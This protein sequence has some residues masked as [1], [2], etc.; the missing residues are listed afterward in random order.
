MSSAR[1]ITRDSG[2]D[3]EHF[4][5]RDAELDVLRECARTVRAGTPC[6]VRIDGPPGIGKTALVRRFLAGLDGFRVLRAAADPSESVIGYGVIHQLHRRLDRELVDRFPLLAS[7]GT[8]GAAPFAVGAD[9]LG[10]LGALQA[11]GPVAVVVDDLQW[12]DEPSVQALGFALRRLWGDQ[13]LI[14]LVNRPGQDGEQAASLR[15][16]DG[17]GAQHR[18]HL[19]G[20]SEPE[21]RA[22]A[23]QLVHTPLPAHAVDR[24]YTQTLGHPLYARALAVELGPQ[25]LRE[26]ARQWPVPPSLQATVQTNLARLP[27]PARRLVEALAVL[28]K[29]CSLARVATLAGVVEPAQALRDALAADLAEWWPAEPSSPVALRHPLLRDAVYE[30]LDP[31]RRRE[32]HA[33]AAPLVDHESS[34]LHRVA[35]AESSDPELAAELEAAAGE[36]ADRGRAE[37]AATYLLWAAELSGSRAEYERRLLTASLQSLATWRASWA[38]RLLPEVERCADS[39]LRSCVIGVTTLFGKGD[40]G[41]AESWLTRA[42]AEAQRRPEL[43]W[44]TARAA[45]FQSGLHL[46]QGKGAETVRAARLALS[47]GLLEPATRDVVQMTLTVGRSREVGLRTALDE[48]AHLP[49]PA[50]RTAATDLESLACRGA[51]R[52]MLGELTGA[53]DDLSTVVHRQRGGAAAQ[54]MQASYSY[55]ATVRYLLGD[56]DD[57]AITAERG[58]SVVESGEQLYH[59][60]LGHLAATF[61]PAGRGDWTAAQEHARAARHWAGMLGTPQDDRYAAVAEAVLAQ[62]NADYPAMLAALGGLRASATEDGAQQHAWWQSWWRPLL[63]EALVGTGHLDEA[64]RALDVMERTV[65]DVPYLRLVQARL[66]GWLAGMRGDREG[67]LR[68]YRAGLD[69]AAEDAPLYQAPLYRGMLEQWCGR[70]HQALHQRRAAIELLRRAHDRYAALGAHPFRQRCAVD[71]AGCGLTLD[72]VD[73]VSLRLTARE[74]DV[75]HLIARGFSND[76][77]ARELYVSVK[78]IEYHLGNIYS[79]LAITSRHEL[80]VAIGPRSS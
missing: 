18:I 7:R 62:A 9:L 60:A 58:L 71:L 20:L 31:A 35:A 65:G 3:A 11:D 23:E 41:L 49:E 29:R 80:A 53:A 66:R 59:Y 61:V 34:W 52:T 43:G 14:V 12:A 48:M 47:T 57:G 39:P 38:M 6:L 5:G 1:C 68:L 16:P 69:D 45:A 25:H 21:L 32:L 15:L 44:I 79:K 77:A 72:P 30:S 13:V 70:L 42:L 22:L 55:L 17:D 73:D 74:R 50:R 78:T 67:A 33:A 2:P 63:A 24:L 27:A 10:L 64:G 40:L 51:L 37:V 56:W 76:R 8:A 54:L 46:W 4:V 75:A 19:G 28:D 26:T 36:E